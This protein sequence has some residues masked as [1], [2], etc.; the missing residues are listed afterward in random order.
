MKSSRFYFQLVPSTHRTDATEYGLLPTPVV[1]DMEGGDTDTV[2][3]KNGRFVR[4]S[5]DGTEFG[6]KIQ[7]A[8]KLLPTPQAID[9][10]GKGR[11]LRMKTGNRNPDSVGSWRGDLKDYAHMDLLP[12][13]RAN[14]SE[15]RGQISADPRN[16][17]PGLAV[18][19]FL[20]T[21][22]ASSDAKGGC[23]RP[24]EKR[25]NDTLAHSIHGMVGEPGKTSQLNPRFV[26]EM[27]GFPPDWTE[28]PFQSGE[29]NP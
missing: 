10:S 27:M 8:A 2:S 4:I 13:P 9:G 17:L 28:L 18:N 7:H 11:A 26:L 19:G 6:A 15:K 20:P 24:N 3:L 16:G 29:M 23:T 22:T 21:Q 25:Q 14:D 1:S 12:T 5:K